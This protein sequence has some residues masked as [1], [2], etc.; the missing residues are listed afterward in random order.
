MI[1]TMDVY[2]DLVQRIISTCLDTPNLWHLLRAID[3][4]QDYAY[5]DTDSLHYA[6]YEYEDYHPTISL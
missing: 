4:V 2:R 3:S 1:S 6:D 5:T